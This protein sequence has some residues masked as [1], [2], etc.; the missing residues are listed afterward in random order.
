MERRRFLGLGV[1]ALVGAR[2]SGAPAIIR[3]DAA[4]PATPCGV[5]TGD[6]AE[7]QA[8]VWSR[9]DRPARLIVEYSTTA[10]F[11]DPRRVVGPAALENADFTARVNLTD[12]PAGQRISYRARF[13]DLGDLRLFSLPVEG[14]FRTAPDSRGAAAADRDQLFAFTADCVGQ[15][16]GIDRARGGLRV[17]EAMRRLQPDVFVH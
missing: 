6:V 5:A 10:S 2:Q 11:S 4:R 7:G 16:W 3:R 15:G 9:T 12:L 14:S 13:Q 8:I 17:Y 1:A